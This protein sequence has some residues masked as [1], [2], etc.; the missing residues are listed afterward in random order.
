MG[1]TLDEKLLKALACPVCKVGVKKINDCLLSCT[2]CG[3][4]YPII[5]GVPQMLVNLDKKKVK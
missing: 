3:R 1:K 2:K 4:K 5:D